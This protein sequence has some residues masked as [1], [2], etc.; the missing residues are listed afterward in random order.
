MSEEA[1]CLEAKGEE[2]RHQSSDP[3]CEVSEAP[4][5]KAPKEAALASSSVLS[6]RC[7]SQMLRAKELILNKHS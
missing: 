4:S 6:G 5:V 1:S 3:H 7:S 2:S